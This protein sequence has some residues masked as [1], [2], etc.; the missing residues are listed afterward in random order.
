GRRDRCARENLP[1]HRGEGDAAHAGGSGGHQGDRPGGAGDNDVA[2]RDL[3]PGG[4][5][6]RHHRPGDDEVRLAD[7]V[8]T[9]GF[10]G[11]GAKTMSVVASFGPGAF[12][13]GISGR[14][15]TSFG[16]TMAFAIMVS[17]VVSFTLTPMMSARMLK[18]RRPR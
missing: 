8:R 5:H 15:M 4:V 7:G 18:L 13:S 2:R 9:S 6:E 11:G 1:V 10:L 16:L 12:R 17:L 3:R 14:F